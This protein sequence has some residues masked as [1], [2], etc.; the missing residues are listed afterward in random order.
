MTYVQYENDWP[1]DELTV[2]TSGQSYSANPAECGPV[3]LGA[4]G[5]KS[6]QPTL[7]AINLNGLIP[8]PPIWWILA[9]PGD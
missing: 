7:R 9:M 6:A 1:D 3:L 2:V 8:D 5:L 4:S